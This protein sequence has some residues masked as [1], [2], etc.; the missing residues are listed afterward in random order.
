MLCEVH[1][2]WRFLM[3]IALASKPL[4][5]KL[6]GSDFHLDFESRYP[7]PPM[8]QGVLSGRHARWLE[9][10]AALA[11]SDGAEDWPFGA[12]LVKGGRVL[13]AEP[14]RRH[15]DPSS[16]DR[17]WLSGE[18]A[19]AAV[20]RRASNSQGATLYVARVDAFGVSKIAQPCIRC[21]QR[22]EAAGIRQVFWT[23]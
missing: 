1:L 12:V 14:N 5:G 19:E 17:P 20:I 13:A 22:I 23:P 8:P 16:L 15:N 18:H 9:Y 6:K 11:R 3:S 10:A 7:D 21:W 4:Q 2:Y